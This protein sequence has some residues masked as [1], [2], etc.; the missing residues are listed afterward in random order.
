[1]RLLPAVLAYS[2]ATALPAAAPLRFGFYDDN[3]TATPYANIHQSE[4]LA[5]ARANWAAHPTTPSILSVDDVVFT[6]APHAMILQ[7]D[8]REQLSALATAAAP[9]FLSGAIIGYNLGDELVWNCLA[10][11][12]LT[13][14]ADAV[15]ALCP[16]AGS[17]DF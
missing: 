7:T 5:D 14:V 8:W 10:P 12:N 15:R 2:T 6:S 9:D 16:P 13:L 1:M 4:S 11:S 3:V 17:C